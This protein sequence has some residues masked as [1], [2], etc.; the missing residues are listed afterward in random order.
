MQNYSV[1]LS[2][3]KNK[4]LIDPLHSFVPISKYAFRDLISFG[5]EVMINCV[6]FAQLTEVHTTS[7]I[8]RNILQCDF[9]KNFPSKLPKQRH[10]F[11]SSYQ[12]GD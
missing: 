1:F 10:F 12:T 2:H 3:I 6:W 4:H 11:H 9:C 8:M 5:D 7:F